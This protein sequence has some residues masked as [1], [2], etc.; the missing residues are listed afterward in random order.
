MPIDSLRTVPD[1][2]RQREVGTLVVGRDIHPGSWSGTATGNCYWAR[3]SGFA[4]DFDT[5]IAN[6]NVDPGS[7]LTIT[8]KASDKGL[9]LGSDCGVLTRS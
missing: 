7:K 2:V 1:R 5:I 8:V 3:L 6:D 4:G 9:Q